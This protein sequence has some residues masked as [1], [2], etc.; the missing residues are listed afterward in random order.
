VPTRL[1]NR[2][3]TGA[4]A[5]KPDPGWLTLWA[6]SMGFAA[7][8]MAAVVYFTEGDQFGAAA[9][10]FGVAALIAAVLFGPGL[11]RRRKKRRH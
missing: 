7:A 4:E 2:R 5:A 6:V 3:R 8:L 1:P 9:V 11:S 10:L